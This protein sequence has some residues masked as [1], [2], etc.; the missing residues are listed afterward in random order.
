MSTCI[1]EVYDYELLKKCCTC[2]SI[3]LK[4]NFYKKLSS[5]VE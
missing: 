4:S 1:E 2:K 3:C 5:K